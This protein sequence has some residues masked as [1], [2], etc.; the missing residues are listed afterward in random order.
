LKINNE[1]KMLHENQAPGKMLQ[2]GHT[3]WTLTLAFSLVF[4]SEDRAH[5][6]A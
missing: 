1:K 3:P 5:T 4:P 2:N 6:Q